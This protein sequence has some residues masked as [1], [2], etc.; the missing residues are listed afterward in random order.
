MLTVFMTVAFF[1]LIIGDLIIF[2]QKALFH[3]DIFSGQPFSKP[4][5]SEN[6][7]KVKDKKDRVHANLLTF[8][9][10][11]FEIQ[12]DPFYQ[13]IT[14]FSLPTISSNTQDVFLSSITY[15][16]PPILCFC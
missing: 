9:S 11:V 3:N 15:R 10:D 13:S 5:K 7:Y 2:H 16:G 6:Y 4:N 8:V 14:V 12:E 1:Y